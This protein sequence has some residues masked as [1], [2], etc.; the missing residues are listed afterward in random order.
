[1]NLPLHRIALLSLALLT[2]TAAHL[3]FA[4]LPPS[5]YRP[6]QDKA[7]EALVIAVLS[8]KSEVTEDAKASRVH[9]EARARVVEVKRTA[10]ELKV[11][12]E[13]N[14]AYTNYQ[15]KRDQFIVGP[16]SYIP[17]LEEGKVVP[18]YL[19]GNQKNGYLPAAQG[20]SF[21]EIR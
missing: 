5:A 16:G 20:Y 13:I 14:I 18:A 8:V 15:L 11:G 17:V 19:S 6:E 4:A 3:A 21:K 2:G 1:M 12:D 10:S 7:P 9:V